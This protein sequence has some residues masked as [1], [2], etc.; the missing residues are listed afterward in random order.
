MDKPSL[1]TATLVNMGLANMASAIAFAL[2]QGNMARIFQ[3]FGANLDTLPILMIAGPVT[4]LVVQPLVGHFS[5][6]TWGPLGRRRPYFLAGALAAAA[7]LL[8]MSFA[9]SLIVAVICFW[10]LDSALNVV[11][12]PFRAFVGDMV[13]AHQRARGLS[14]NSALGCS[15]A[16]LG[17][18]LPFLLTQSHL[19]GH[20]GTGE[21]APSLRISLV[22][23][24]V[25]LVLGVGWTVWRVR[26]Y[27]PQE[28][29]HF[30]GAAQLPLAKAP[31]SPPLVAPRQGHRWLGAGLALTAIAAWGKLDVQIYALTIG[32]ALFG[33][34]Q[35]ANARWHN[36]SAL[37][38]ILSDLTQMPKPM[39]KLALIHSC[40]WFALFIMWP[41][42]T[43]VIT[44]YAFHTTDPASAAYNAGADW[45][46][47]L[48]AGFN[49]A[50]ALF[51]FA[52]LPGLARRLGNG[53]AHA[54]CLGT[55]VAGFVA[56]GFV[57]D[58]Y[59][60]FAPFAALGI[61]WASL[62]TLPYVMLTN[63]L[64]GQKLGIYTGI[65]NFFV[66]LPQLLVA[67]IMGPVLRVCFPQDPIWTMAIAAVAMALAATLTLVLRP[68][69]A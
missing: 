11:I 48:F 67:T 64:G 22:L 44:Q 53:P 3:N 58:P 43:P 1:T 63:A 52:V 28:L 37:A 42:M 36:R 29:A 6:R 21:M 23:A 41:F 38:E 16:V 4:G 45:V 60:L 15:G 17:F 12:E 32:L 61:A 25:V 46:G 54:L 20:A 8:G 51:G 69:R 59:V 50:A 35:M 2:Q 19:L 65:F 57:R 33:G 27:S 40:T 30:A 55:G 62:L 66:V 34:L 18:A 31:L 24:A 9:T 10:V 5:D 68:D 39:R 13:P 56:L 49:V 26:E 47:M 7:A 14:I